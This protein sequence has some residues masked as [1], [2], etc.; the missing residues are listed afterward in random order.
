MDESYTPQQAFSEVN[1]RLRDLEERQRLLNER[2]LLMGKNFIEER[3]KNFTEVQNL[4]KTISQ[5]KEELT[6]ASDFLQRVGEQL[7]NVARKEELLV[8]QRQFDLFRES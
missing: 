3:T 5:M 8:L 4:K 1:T 2:V 7:S 6:K